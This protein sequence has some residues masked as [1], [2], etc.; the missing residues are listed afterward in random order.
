MIKNLI[1]DIGNV[2]CEWNPERLC[3]MGGGTPEQQAELLEIT[4]KHDDWLLLDK[5][6]INAEQAKH[7]AIQRSTLPAEMIGA[8]YDNTPVSLTPLEPTLAAMQRAA[9]A[10]VPM[11][12]LS[13]MAEHSW[14][15]LKANIDCWRLCKGIVTSWEAQLMKPDKAIYEHLCNQYNLVPAE[16]I[17]IDDMKVNID[18]AIDCGWQGEQLTDPM[19]GGQ[20]I[21]DI[22][23]RIV[24]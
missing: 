9:D 18:A 23:A 7:N 24:A 4:I 11:Y 16:C 5:G 10:G 14:H 3:S 1:L 8:V 15:Y 12:I 22:V 17:F 6:L 13:N 20:L 2:I 19:M 21:D